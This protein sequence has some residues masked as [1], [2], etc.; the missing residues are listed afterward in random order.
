V[1]ADRGACAAKHDRDIAEAPK[2]AGLLDRAVERLLERGNE[3]ERTVERIVEK[4]DRG[5]P[6]AGAM[7]LVRG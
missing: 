2:R 1:L 6:L 4:F 7:L 5:R 3:V